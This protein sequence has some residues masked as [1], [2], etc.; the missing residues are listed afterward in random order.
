MCRTTLGTISLH[1]CSPPP[2]ATSNHPFSPIRLL[3]RS[4]C[5]TH[6][7]YQLRLSPIN[8]HCCDRSRSAT[9]HL[10]SPHFTITRHHHLSSIGLPHRRNLVPTTTNYLASYRHSTITRLHPHSSI[11]LLRRR[12]VTISPA[13]MAITQPLETSRTGST[14]VPITRPIYKKTLPHPIG[15]PR[16]TTPHHPID[17]QKYL[18]S[19]TIVKTVHRLCPVPARSKT[20][21]VQSVCLLSTQM[22]HRVVPHKCRAPLGSG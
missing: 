17:I 22:Q 20:S 9:S 10:D 19:L 4:L 11:S 2:T 8:P 6:R 1:H 13:I 7:P 15:H 21:A 3:R 14:M 5:P 16:T 18:C 12:R